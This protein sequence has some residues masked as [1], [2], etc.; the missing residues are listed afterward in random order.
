[1]S[2]GSSL[3]DKAR[4]LRPLIEQEAAR[5]E[6]ETT[7]TRVVVDALADAELFWVLVPRELGGGEA[8]IV[9]AVAVFEELAY[10][11][12]STGWSAMA[13][14][15]SSAFAAIYTGDDAA[16]KMFGPNGRGIHAG[17][18][19]PVG[20]ARATDDGF[21]VSGKYQ[22]GSGCA[23]ASWFAAGTQE[24]DADGT[25]LNDDAGRAR[26]AHRLP[27]PGTGGRARQ[28]GCARARGHG[29]LRL[30]RRRRVRR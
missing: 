30:H 18:F 19:G 1:V 7:T 8:S 25:P 26:D 24:V 9:D 3:V 22:F 14:A 15:T 16:K 29:Q 12:G 23:H 17:M 28:L 11:D 27:A 21:S 5:A 13:N 4:S 20:T 10:A 6:A 2:E